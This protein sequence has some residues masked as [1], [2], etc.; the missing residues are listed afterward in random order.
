M[1]KSSSKAIMQISF[2]LMKWYSGQVIYVLCCIFQIQLIEKYLEDELSKR[3]LEFSMAE[4][5]RLIM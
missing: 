4:F 5:T 2:M 3:I 1:L